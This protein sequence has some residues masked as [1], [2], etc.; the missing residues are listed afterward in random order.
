LLFAS[1]LCGSIWRGVCGRISSVIDLVLWFD[2]AIDSIS[3]RRFD[4]FE[5]GVAG[6][7]CHD[8]SD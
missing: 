7:R 1:S 5:I 6:S 4:L 8:L 3:W 2:L